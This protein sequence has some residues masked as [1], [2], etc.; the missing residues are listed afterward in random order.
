MLPCEQGGRRDDR[1]LL[2]V[3]RRDEGGAQGDLRL[4]EADIAA[5]EP[6]HR[7]P[8][9]EIVQHIGDGTI[10]IVGFLPR[11]AVD[12]LVVACPIGGQDRRLAKC[13]RRGGFHQLARDCADTLAQLRAAFLPRLAAQPVELHRFFAA[14]VPGED[15]DI[16]DRDEQLVSAAIFQGHAVVLALSDGDRF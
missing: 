9:F 13:A 11:E 15:V 16:L 8:A 14:A 4:A 6:V 3:H 1:D 12:E 5:D 10:L 2:A 7:A